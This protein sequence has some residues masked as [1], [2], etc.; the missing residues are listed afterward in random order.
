MRELADEPGWTQSWL[1]QA[2]RDITRAHDLPAPQT[3]VYVEGELV[4]AAWP[5]RRLVVEVD[6]WRFHKTRRSFEDDRRKD[7]KL[8]VRHWRVVRFTHRRVTD[9]PAGVGRD[10]S[11][12]LRDGPSP[13]RAR[14]GP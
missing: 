1:E 13:R 3:N 9:D 5:E 6:G 11:E 2:L 8:V 7:A 4:D 14:S 10:L 12:L